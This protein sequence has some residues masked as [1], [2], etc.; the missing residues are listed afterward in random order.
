MIL[1]HFVCAFANPGRFVRSANMTM[2]GRPRRLLAGQ[3]CRASPGER[4]PALLGCAALW[5]QFNGKRGT[6]KQKRVLQLQ[7]CRQGS[8]GSATPFFSVRG[9]GSAAMRCQGSRVCLRA[10][11]EMMAADCPRVRATGEA[12]LRACQNNHKLNVTGKNTFP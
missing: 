1:A 2:N 5:A 11:D 9:L 10:G 4:H 6:C 8:A 12:E 7:C 3:V